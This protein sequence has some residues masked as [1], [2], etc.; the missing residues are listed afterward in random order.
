MGED[1]VDGL[2]VRFSGTPWRMEVGAPFLGGDNED[3]FGRLLGL[4]PAE[5]AALAEVGVI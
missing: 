1:R 5:V 2:P 3:V 4:S